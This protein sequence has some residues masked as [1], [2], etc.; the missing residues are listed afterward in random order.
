VANL[1]IGFFFP[2]T[3][4]P[5]YYRIRGW[6]N[7]R[8]GLDVSESIQISCPTRNQTNCRSARIRSLQYIHATQLAAY[9]RYSVCHPT[10][11]QT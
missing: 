3:N 10:A 6:V 5:Q 1:D 2:Q 9:P 8:T 4:S 11:K 7:P